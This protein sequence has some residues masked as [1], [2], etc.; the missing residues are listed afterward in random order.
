MGP[1]TDKHAVRESFAKVKFLFANNG[2]S[3][4]KEFCSTT[5][6]KLKCH[7]HTCVC[8]FVC[9]LR[10]CDKTNW[11]CDLMAQATSLA[12]ICWF[13]TQKRIQ[14]MCSC[15][16]PLTLRGV[17]WQRVQSMY[18][19]RQLS[20]AFCLGFFWLPIGAKPLPK[21]DKSAP[22][23]ATATQLLLRIPLMS[24]SHQMQTT[25]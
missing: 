9:V 19:R 20:R 25:T 15:F 17:C 8:M 10:C 24:T 21:S 5:I 13:A 3:G 11:G 12:T 7:M 16:L 18:A 6:C 22:V 23:W 14:I 4:I 1:A 2:R